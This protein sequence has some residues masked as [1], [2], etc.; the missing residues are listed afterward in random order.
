MDQIFFADSL[1][2]SE[3]SHNALADGLSGDPDL[4]DATIK[5]QF[6]SRWVAVFSYCGGH[7]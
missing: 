6:D 1:P 7:C 4:R 5:L 3:I 2:N